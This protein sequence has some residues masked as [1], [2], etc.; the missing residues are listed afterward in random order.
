MISSDN[1]WLKN[2]CNKI[3]CNS[4]MCMRLY[5]LDYLYNQANI[6]M[7][8]RQHI[9]LRL[10]SDL[11]DKDAFVRLKSI[12]DDII[13]FV[14]GGYSVYIHSQNCGNGKTSWA[15]RFAQSYL[16]KIWLKSSL[17]C[18]VLF[19]NVPRF[20]LALK[21]NISEKSDYVQHIKENVL[22]CDLVIW[23][24]IGTKSLS[25]FEHENV[26]NLVNA[27]IDSGKSN[28]YT[29]N[30]TNDE[31]HTA[32]GDRLYS[33]I[34]ELSSDIELFGSDKRGL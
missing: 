1:C 28:I 34:V 8:Q 23:D 33:R 9:N 20:L 26:L 11:R 22:N 24:E 5:K 3:D 18:K 13:N 17:E 30:L 6:S 10:D 12:E 7:T 32:V 27:R 14:K 31:L 16:N 19:I 15:L 21:D 29:S 4:P 2:N 25:T